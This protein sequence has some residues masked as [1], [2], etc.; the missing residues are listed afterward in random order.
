[1]GQPNVENQEEVGCVGLELGTKIWAR[2]GQVIRTQVNTFEVP[3]A[4]LG[5]GTDI[6]CISLRNRA[7]D[8]IWT[9]NEE[10]P[11]HSQSSPK[12]EW[13]LHESGSILLFEQCKQSLDTQ[14]TRKMRALRSWI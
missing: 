12:T 14:V 7:S 5:L 11:S 10:R 3:H 8:Q 2:K 1:M 6:F 9:S 4:C 13:A